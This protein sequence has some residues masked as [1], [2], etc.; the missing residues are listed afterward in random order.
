MVIF[1]LYYCED[2]DGI[3]KG[4]LKLNFGSVVLEIGDIVVQL[5]WMKSVILLDV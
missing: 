3:L 5:L 2:I 1:Y 4:L